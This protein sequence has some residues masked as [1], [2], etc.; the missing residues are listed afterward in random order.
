MPKKENVIDLVVY[1]TIK[2]TEFDFKTSDFN[3]LVFTSPSNVDTFHEKYRIE[4]HQKIVA[5]GDATAHALK[6]YLVKINKQPASFDDLG[7][8]QAVFGI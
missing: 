3:V 8:V 7:L 5:M 4:P 1:E 2:K 6:K